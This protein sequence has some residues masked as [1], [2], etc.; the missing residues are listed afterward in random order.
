MS[1]LQRSTIVIIEN[2]LDIQEMIAFNFRQE[3]YRVFTSMT[4]EDGLLK[5]KSKKPNIVLLDWM[6]PGMTGIE[7]CKSIRENE[8]IKQTKVVMLT[9][10]TEE[11]DMVLGLEIGADDYITKPFSTKVLVA[12]I[13]SIVRRE[14]LLDQPAKLVEDIDLGN[15]KVQP[16][17]RQVMINDDFIKLTASEFAAFQLLALKPGWVVSRS[18]IV[19]GI[20]GPGHVVSNRAIDVMMVSL[21]KKLGKYSDF[22]ETIR[23]TG[24]CLNTNKISQKS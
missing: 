16:G 4:G 15:V 21:R 24:Y 1:D 12:K 18:Q 10:K 8:E 11:A 2:D 13:N 20:H 7:V 19:E 23:G 14:N 9:A 3:G 5:I 6:L 22:V 17:R